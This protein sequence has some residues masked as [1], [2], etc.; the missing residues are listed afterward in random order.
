MPCKLKNRHLYSP[1]GLVS[2][3]TFGMYQGAKYHINK[4]TIYI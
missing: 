3:F 1:V 4:D 2:E